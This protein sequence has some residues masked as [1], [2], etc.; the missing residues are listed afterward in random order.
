MVADLPYSAQGTD[1]NE[2]L[3]Q[4]RFSPDDVKLVALPCEAFLEPRDI[5]IC[6]ARCWSLDRGSKHCQIEFEE[7]KIVRQ[8]G[9]EQA[10]VKTTLRPVFEVQSAFLHYM[11]CRA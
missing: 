1:E 7:E 11:G 10:E 4:Y 5:S 6:P 9:A 3:N 8:R 2:S